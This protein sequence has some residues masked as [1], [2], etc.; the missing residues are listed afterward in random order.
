VPG[1]LIALVL[2][3]VLPATLGAALL[4]DKNALLLS[5]ACAFAIAA[6]SLNILMGYAG[7]ISLGQFA[8]V[9]VGAFTTGIV[10]SSTSCGCRGWPGW[11]PRRD[12]SA[13]AFLVG[14]PALR[15]RGLYLAVVTVAVAYVGWQSL[16]RVEWIGGGSAGKVTPRPYFG[17]TRSSRTL[18]SSPSPP[19]CSC[20]CGRWT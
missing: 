2:A 20:W 7:Q 10:T 13:I 14:L 5:A 17:D 16:F 1:I 11:S 4:S 3:A 8:F 18:G 9:G 19:S 12:R 6:I 15:L